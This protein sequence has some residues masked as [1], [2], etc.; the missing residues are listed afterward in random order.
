MEFFTIDD[1][2]N[3]LGE[4]MVSKKEG[5]IIQ[6]GM[7]IRRAEVLIDGNIRIKD[8]S[9]ELLGVGSVSGGDLKMETRV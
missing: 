3:H 2:L 7:K 8:L 9:G 6:A 4:V 5:K 1:G